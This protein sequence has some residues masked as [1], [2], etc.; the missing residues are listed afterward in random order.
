VDGRRRL[1]YLDPTKGH[2]FSATFGVTYNNVNHRHRLQNGIDYHLD[3]A[4]AQFLN[5]QFYVG[6][7]GYAYDQFTDDKG[8]PAFVQDPKSARVRHWAAAGLPVRAAPGVA[9]LFAVK[10]YYEFESH[11]RAEGWNVC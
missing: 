6:A 7:V 1:Y 5:K 4:A 9:G 8:A 3:V 2:E 11:Y 10:G